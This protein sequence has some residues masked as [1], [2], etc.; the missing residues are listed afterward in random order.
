MTAALAVTCYS[1][2]QA[3]RFHKVSRKLDVFCTGGE[4]TVLADEHVDPHRCGGCG[5]RL[6]TAAEICPRCIHRSQILGRVWDILRPQLMWSIMLCVLTIVGV[7]AELVPPKLQQ[8]LVDNVLGEH[9]IDEPQSKFLQA[10][11]LVVLALAGSR[12]TL[13]VV[14]VF[15]GRL[16]TSI[17]SSLTHRLRGEMVHKLQKLAISYYDRHQVGSLMS[18]VAY[19]SEVRHGLVHQLTGGF[20]LQILQLVGVGGMLI[21]LNPRLA[22][23]TLSMG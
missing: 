11:L 12:V 15:K 17:G 8:Y 21:W 1:N 19:D 2:A 18:R 22:V 16:A 23:Y 10:L 5:L 3:E 7:A 13:S 4:L 14:G 9:A 20:L 6:S